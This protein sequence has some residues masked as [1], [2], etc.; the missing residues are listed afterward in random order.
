MGGGSYDFDVAREAR[1]S[2]TSVFS[3]RGHGGTAQEAT[4]RQTVH[5]ALNPHGA[6]RECNNETPIVVAMDVTRSRGDDTKIIYDKL[7][8]LI[9]QIVMKNYV[10]GPAISFAAIGDATAGDRAPLQVGQFEADNRLDDVLSRIWIEDGGGGSGQE[11]YE[12]AAYFYARHTKLVRQERGE[13]KKGFF[14]FLGDEGFYPEVSQQQIRSVLGRDVPQSVPSAQIFAEL[15]RKFHVFLIF[16]QKSMQERKSDIDAEIKKRVEA[17]GGLYEGVD[18]RASL[19][20]DNRND[21]DLHVVTPSG[22]HIYYG[23]KR[24]ACGGWLDVDQN[25][26]GETTKPVENVRW[27]KGTAPQGRYRVYVQNYRFHEQD[28]APTTFRV[29]IEVNGVVRH[30][31]NTISPKGEVG[32][33]SNLSVF[34]FDFDPNQRPAAAPTHQREYDNYADDVILAQ[35]ESVIPK[36]HILKIQDP[37][38]IVDVML[39]ALALVGGDRDLDGY[40]DDMRGREQLDLRQDQAVQTLGSLASAMSMARSAVSG[41]VPAPDREGKST[42][43]RRL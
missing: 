43:S 28:R 21:L 18:V 34:E 31:E 35:W 41:S 15:A 20:W 8:L 2:S 16:P 12:L 9:G 6:H 32:V 17:A 29:E 39:G 36:E 26:R 24:S 4:A 22:E 23:S 30:F 37:K 19:I 13:G 42:R 10:G 27:R 1:S 11:S 40:L 3:Y 7:P 14:F 25:V 33:D 5:P 38:A